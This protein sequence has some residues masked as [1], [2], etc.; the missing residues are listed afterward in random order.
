MQPFAYMYLYTVVVAVVYGAWAVRRASHRERA[1]TWRQHRGAIV[2]IGVMNM[3]SYG[4]T[5]VALTRGTS[6]LVI[7]LRQLSIVAGVA[8]GWLVLREA[9]GWPRRIGVAMIAIGCVLIATR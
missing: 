6:S 4:L 1:D 8:L 5:L 7:G 2:G 3:V 9:I